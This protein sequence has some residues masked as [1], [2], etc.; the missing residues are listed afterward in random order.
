[1]IFVGDC[2]DILPRLPEQSVQL[3]MTSPPYADARKHTYGGIRDAEYVDWFM[4][5]AE[6]LRRVLRPDGTMIINIKEHARGG[7][8]NPYVLHLILAMID[9]GWFWTEEMI[10][11]KP[12]PSPGKWPNRFKDAWERLLQFSL[13]TNPKMY[14]D[15]VRVSLSG[16]GKEKL[17]RYVQG[18]HIMDDSAIGSGRSLDTRRVAESMLLPDG[19]TIRPG[20]AVTRATGSRVEMNNAQITE[21][22]AERA[23]ALP[24]NVLFGS[25]LGRNHKHSA[26]YPEWLPEWFIELF[27]DPGDIV[28]DPFVGSGTTCR[29][30]HALGRATIGIDIN[31]PS[32][33]GELPVW[34]PEV[35]DAQG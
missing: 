7:V 31:R 19:R 27:T 22:M 24:T 6:E 12:N 13:Q 34:P 1:M 18:N 29:V 15:R 21:Q 25:V 10:W 35:S 16:G 3:V 33:P 9:A 30:A 32:M 20:G 26:A 8:R 17:R 4:P 11:H 28:L 23:S 2:R 14:Q 5:I